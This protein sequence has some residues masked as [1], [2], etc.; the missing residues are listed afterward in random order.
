MAGFTL[1]ID[2]HGLCMFAAVPSQPDDGSTGVMHVLFPQAAGGMDG[3]MAGHM[4]SMRHIAALYFDCGYLNSGDIATRTI[5]GFETQVPLLGQILELPGSG[6]S[7]KMC[8]DVL[9]LRSATKVPVD[10]ALFGKQGLGRIVAR[11]TFATGSNTAVDPGYCW[12]WQGSVRRL[13]YIIRW[14]VEYPADS[15]QFTCS[16]LDGGNVTPPPQLYPV[17]NAGKPEMHLSVYHVTPDDLPLKPP[18]VPVPLPPGAPPM[19]FGAF[20]QLYPPGTPVTLPTFDS[21]NG[22]ADSGCD[23]VSDLGASP[24]NC[25]G[26][27]DP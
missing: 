1:H 7:L 11:M 25:M 6:A 22:C 21:V 12:S 27:G 2:F 3:E 9:G 10:T 19:H 8:P 23:G 5:V 14:T 15:L 24:Y 13:A 26:V 4:A 17:N 16:A 18:A 20:Y